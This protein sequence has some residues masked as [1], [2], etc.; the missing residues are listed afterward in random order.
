MMFLTS[1]L[2]EF[3]GE[4]TILLKGTLL[5]KNSCKTSLNFYTKI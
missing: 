4:K 2:N 5:S 3:N 1:N